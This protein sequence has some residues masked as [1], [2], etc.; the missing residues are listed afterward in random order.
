M[1]SCYEQGLIDDN[2]IKFKE[3]VN[4]EIENG[5]LLEDGTFVECNFAEHSNYL[6]CIKLLKEE[7]NEQKLLKFNYFKDH[8]YERSYVDIDFN[9]KLTKNQIDFIIRNKENIE[10]SI[11]KELTDL[12][13]SQLSKEEFDSFTYYLFTF[14]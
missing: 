12:L 3:T 9:H 11:L 8:D 10:Q 2:K 4:H 13:K 7:T 5:W 6:K 1:L 14:N